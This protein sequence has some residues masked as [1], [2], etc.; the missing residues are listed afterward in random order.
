MNGGFFFAKRW[1][2]RG[3]AGGTC[4]MKNIS[5]FL[6][7]QGSCDE[8]PTLFVPENVELSFPALFSLAMFAARYVIRLPPAPGATSGHFHPS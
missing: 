8:I 3:L 6:E 4:F 1:C 5:A 2:W 7:I